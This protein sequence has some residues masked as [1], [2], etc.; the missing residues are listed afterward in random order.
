MARVRVELNHEG[1][2]ELL[3]S[4]E[5]E[6]DLAERATRVAAAAAESGHRP[7]SGTVEYRVETSRGKE[8]VRALVLADHP[9]AQGLE[10]RYRTLGTA[11]DAAK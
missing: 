5:V 2:G 3:L 4:P 7:H 1:M 11:I 6:A 9:G 8:R 10:A